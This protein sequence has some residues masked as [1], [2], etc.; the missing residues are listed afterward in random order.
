MTATELPRYRLTQTAHIARTP[1]AHAEIL[2][3]GAEVVFLGL[4][5]SHMHPVNEAAARVVQEARDGTKL[6]Q[7]EAAYRAELLRLKEKR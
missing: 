4:P 6:S 1:G 5:G 7:L 2:H 3:A